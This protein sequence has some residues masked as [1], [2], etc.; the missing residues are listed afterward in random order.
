MD[1]SRLI[2]RRTQ[3]Q[4]ALDQLGPQCCPQERSVVLAH[5][6]DWCTD[7]SVHA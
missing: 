3:E 5:R 2:S 1:A 4:Q 6:H 7:R